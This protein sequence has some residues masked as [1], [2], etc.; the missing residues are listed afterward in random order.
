MSKRQRGTVPAP[1]AFAGAH[2]TGEAIDQLAALDGTSPEDADLAEQYQAAAQV[3]V[4]DADLEAGLTAE[5]ERLGLSGAAFRRLIAADPRMAADMIADAAREARGTR[6]NI[7]DV[8]PDMVLEATEDTQARIES[9]SA[10]QVAQF[11]RAAIP[12]NARKHWTK[13]YPK[14]FRG[15]DGNLYVL[16]EWWV[17]KE[18][19]GV[20]SSLGFTLT[21]RAPLLPGGPLSCDIHT[22]AGTVCK[23]RFWKAEVKRAHQEA[24]H[25]AELRA[26][27]R[28]QE[29]ER[30]EMERADR[31]RQIAIQERQVALMEQ[32]ATRAG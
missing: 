9:M 5:A 6:R 28:A 19:V 1:A 16:T 12:E 2:L 7:E 22:N 18:M 25:P 14:P 4:T 3:A 26:Q 8:E 17:Q 21:P 27:E 24:K 30:W 11:A 20:Y 15:D 31:L 29:Q 13:M 32:Q 23:K 10:E